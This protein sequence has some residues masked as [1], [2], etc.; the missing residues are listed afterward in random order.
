M[1]VFAFCQVYNEGLLIRR[2]LENVCPYVDKI[3]LTEG[4]LT[5]YASSVIYETSTDDTLQQ[6]V[7]FAEHDP[8]H[9]LVFMSAIT[10]EECK[11]TP[12]N[13]EEWEG[14][15]K[16]HIMAA[17]LELGMEEGDLIY[18]LDA[19]EFIPPAQLC[20]MITV[21]KDGDGIHAGMV[22]EYQ[23][24]Y[25]LNHWFPSSHPRFFRHAKGARFTTTNHFIV[26]DVGD[27]SRMTNYSIDGM[28]HL[29]WSK[30][31]KFIREKVLSFSR[32]S[33]T[34]WFNDVYLVWPRSPE[35][36]Y[37]Q[38]HYI[39]PYYGTGFAEGMSDPLRGPREL[40]KLPEALQ[41]LEIDWL[42]YVKEHEVKLRI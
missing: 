35:T 7:E 17:A 23:L 24:A 5:P 41:G 32:P 22:K 38:N 9:K 33:L 28:F 40:P 14:R 19:D 1:K 10:A 36:A 11:K 18:I 6:I 2:N 37:H 13:R 31:P 8:D 12:G 15:N 39:P 34:R 29:C 4:K 21:F 27:L 30:H 16:N 42:D 3:I 25:G 26:P 20:E